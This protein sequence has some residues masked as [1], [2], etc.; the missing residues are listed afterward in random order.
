[1]SDSHVDPSARRPAR[2]VFRMEWATPVGA[3]K[4]IDDLSP[5]NRAKVIAWSSVPFAAARC[6]RF[7]TRREVYHF[8]VGRDLRVCFRVEQGGGVVLLVGD[9]Y[10]SVRLINS[11]R[12]DLTGRLIPI[13]E[14]IIMSIKKNTNENKDG[15]TLD[16]KAS[17]TPAEPPPS[18]SDWLR[19][20]P[21]VVDRTY[22]HKVRQV[23]E[24]CLAEMAEVTSR[25]EDVR[26]DATLRIQ[27]L[28]Q[29]LDSRV[30]EL[31]TEVATLAK[32][33]AETDQRPIPYGTTR[34]PEPLRWRVT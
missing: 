30:G 11:H 5:E 2:D 24:V 33:I 17:A 15:V 10:G 31:T 6:E 8:R 34:T 18:F 32:A 3:E 25:S 14:S 29:R 16:L 28:S 9:H 13:E 20:L 26:A 22:G 7:E 12:G 21:G 27:A 19:M 23:E 1:M 4:Q